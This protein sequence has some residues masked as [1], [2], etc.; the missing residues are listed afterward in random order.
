MFSPIVHRDVHGGY[1]KQA[2]FLHD[3]TAVP[4]ARMNVFDDIVRI[5]S[6]SRTYAA[7]PPQLNP[8]G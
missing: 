7:A 6:N 5:L 1:I 4:P 2:R 3:G 8:P